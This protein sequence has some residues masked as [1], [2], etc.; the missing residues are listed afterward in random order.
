MIGTEFNA[1]R[2]LLGYTDGLSELRDNK[3]KQLGT[4]NIKQILQMSNQLEPAFIKQF[5]LA[6]IYEHAG[7]TEMTDDL[8]FVCLQAISPN[9]SG[10]SIK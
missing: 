1:G 2:I 9:K 6:S 10:N 4:A 7:D 8:S 5:L 3:G